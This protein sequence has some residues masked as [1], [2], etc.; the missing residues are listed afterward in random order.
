MLFPLCG[1]CAV[2]K[3]E[4]CEHSNNERSLS[5]AWVSL[6]LY[7]ALELGYKIV[8]IHEVWDFN[9]MVKYDRNTKLGGLFAAYINAFLRLKQQAD[10][11]PSNCKTDEQK[12][13]YILRYEEVEGIKLDFDKN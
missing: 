6:E 7:K 9:R 8:K 2:T 3:D 11:F 5:G 1:T 4:I 13:E 10:G 12:L